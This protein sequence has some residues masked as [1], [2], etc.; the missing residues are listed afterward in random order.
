[1]N[2][3]ALDRQLSELGYK[4]L[5]IDS[6]TIQEKEI[7]A[8]LADINDEIIR[9][10]FDV[11]LLS[12]TAESG[13]DISVKR[14]FAAQFG[15][16]LG[17]L[18]T[19]SQMQFLRRVRDC[20][21]WFIHCVPYTNLQGYKK[22][23]DLVSIVEMSVRLAFD[24]DDQR[25]I[26]DHALGKIQYVKGTQDY[27]HAREILDT[28]IHE[29]R[30]SKQ[31]LIEALHNAG[32]NVKEIAVDIAQLTREL[33][34]E[35]R[36]QVK[37]ERADQTFNAPVIDI[38]QAR[39]LARSIEKSTEEQFAIDRAFILDKLQG[40]EN[41]ELWKVDFVKWYQEDRGDSVRQLERFHSLLWLEETKLLSQ[42]SLAHNFS[43]DETDSIYHQQRVEL[44]LKPVKDLVSFIPWDVRSD[45][46]MIATVQSLGMLQLLDGR[47]FTKE[48]PEIVSICD[49][50]RSSK[51]VQKALGLASIGRE[52]IQ[53]IQ[54][55]F[56]NFGISSKVTNSK[57]K[58]ENGKSTRQQER[59]YTFISPL[60]ESGKDS[61]RN[62]TLYECI[63]RKFKSRLVDNENQ[64]IK[65]PI[66]DDFDHDAMTVEGI[67]HP[68]N[69]LADEVYS[70]FL[71]VWKS[72]SLL[73][74]KKRIELRREIT[75]MIKKIF[76][77]QIQIA[78]N[79]HLD[80][81][82]DSF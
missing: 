12:P 63:D 22:L 55:I 82:D 48:S 43:D 60:D 1:V 7:K 47:Q 46:G 36:D 68:R 6:K 17:L 51:E 70:D 78:N 38:D 40:I 61:E 77:D 30:N 21:E 65:A 3:E 13:I 45:Y 49:Q 23:D 25:K 52:N 66:D 54:S 33:H 15:L 19:D 8:I 57:K 42:R 50:I 4:V 81:S 75:T 35:V 39:E 20:S 16:F 67:P 41:S 9:N 73:G 18:S 37:L 31:C 28:L 71:D 74:I 69:F 26:L 29:R 11:V 34:K 59:R 27:E 44:G 14:Y 2:L 10:Q 5:R 79:E 56:D 24:Y 32:H 76:F 72:A 58:D 64:P 62:K 53:L 80:I